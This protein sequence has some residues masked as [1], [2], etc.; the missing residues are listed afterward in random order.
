MLIITLY[1]AQ[2]ASKGGIQ[3]TETNLFLVLRG[4][5]HSGVIR[6]GVTTS[7][8][9]TTSVLLLGEKGNPDAFLDE[10]RDGVTAGFL[11]D[12]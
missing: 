10:T 11:T 9:T 6:D 5:E 12:V 8:F 1:N 3:R 4:Y 2:D 7:F